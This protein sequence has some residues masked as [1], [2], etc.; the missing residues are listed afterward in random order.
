MPKR[1]GPS[2][3]FDWHALNQKSVA[4]PFAFRL[5]PQER[6]R[7]ARV[8]ATSWKAMKPMANDAVKT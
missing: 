4:F 7:V 5:S 3:N 2:P 1:M 8:L 6:E